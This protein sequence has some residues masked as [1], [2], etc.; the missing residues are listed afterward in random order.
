MHV[1]VHLKFFINSDHKILSYGHFKIIAQE[2]TWWGE[3]ID[4]K[5]KLYLKHATGEVMVLIKNFLFH[6]FISQFLLMLGFWNLIYLIDT[7]TIF[8]NWF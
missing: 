6:R 8:P 3:G 7:K 4:P 1:V 2:C 5:L